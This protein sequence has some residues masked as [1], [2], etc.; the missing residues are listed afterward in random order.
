M[1][2]TTPWPGSL[3]SI[4]CRL[5]KNITRSVGLFFSRG[6]TPLVSTVVGIYAE[7]MYC[8]RL[9]GRVRGVVTTNDATAR[10]VLDRKTNKREH[11]RFGGN[12]ESLTALLGRIFD[13]LV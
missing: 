7:D 1:R 3:L 4:L 13:W 9:T 10:G 6:P 2:R 11:S 5:A 8:S 12:V